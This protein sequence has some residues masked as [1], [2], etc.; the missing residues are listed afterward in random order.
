[1]AAVAEML[2]CGVTPAKVE[3]LVRRIVDSSSP[4][5]IIAFGSRAR[6]DHDPDSDIDI[7]VIVEGTE[8]NYKRL[9]EGITSGLGLDV[10]LLTVPQER[11]DRYRPWIN[12]VHRQ[13]DREGV[14]LYVRGGQPSDSRSFQRLC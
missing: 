14:R 7:A 4:L 5:A 11:F 1:M 6:G 12:T 2:E 9:P 13:I 3:E 10:D 8:T